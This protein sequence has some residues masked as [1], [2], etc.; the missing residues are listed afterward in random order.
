MVGANLGRALL[1]AGNDVHAIIRAGSS[2]W[3]IADMADDFILHVADLRDADAVRRAV[4]D[5]DPEIIFHLA[6]T[7]E[8]ASTDDRLATMRTNIE[9]LQNLIEATASASR[10]SA[11]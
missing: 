10:R 2:R 8:A 5:A 4:V 6:T 3:R 9:G 1:C 11:T 7:R